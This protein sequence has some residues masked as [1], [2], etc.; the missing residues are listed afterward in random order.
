M[1][2][3]LRL[4]RAEAF[5]FNRLP[6]GIRG[7][8]LVELITTLVIVAVLAVYAAPR[9]LGS[10]IFQ[11][12]GFSD[13]VQASLRYA[14]KVAIAQHRFVCVTIV[15]NSLTLALGAS[16]ACGTNL[17]SLSG[18]GSYVIHAPSDVAVTAVNFNFNAFGRPNAAQSIA[19]TGGG[20]S[21]TIIVEA[22]TGYVHL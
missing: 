16:T 2:F 12:R 8:T 4:I 22:E 9:F 10:A 13:Q 21:T 18:G 14:Q 7:F 20:L 19:V 11:S 17:P 5:M 6:R 3:V 1:V 15:G